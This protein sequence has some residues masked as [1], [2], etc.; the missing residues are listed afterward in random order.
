MPELTEEQK[1]QAVE[2]IGDGTTF[3]KLTLDPI[4]NWA[5]DREVLDDDELPYLKEVYEKEVKL[6]E[7]RMKIDSIKK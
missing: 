1:K 2:A 4:V 6:L 7:K 5:V 3:P